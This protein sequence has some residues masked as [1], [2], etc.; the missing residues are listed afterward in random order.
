MLS[1]KPEDEEKLHPEAL[2]WFSL[3][4]KQIESEVPLEELSDD[5]LDM[6]LTDDEKRDFNSLMGKIGKELSICIDKDGAPPNTNIWDEIALN[7]N[8]LQAKVNLLLPMNTLKTLFKRV[9]E[10]KVAKVKEEQRELE[11]EQRRREEE[12]REKQKKREEEAEAKRREQEADER[13]RAAREAVNPPIDDAKMYLDKPGEYDKFVQAA[14]ET[15]E[16][17]QGRGEDYLD[18]SRTFDYRW[19]LRKIKH[20]KKEEQIRNDAQAQAQAFRARL[21]QGLKEIEKMEKIINQE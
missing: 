9:H 12:A 10:R 11:E 6:F 7:L 16:V 13:W 21:D 18:D 3:L 15:I 5:D 19:C 14:R 1:L 20:R 17:Y 2:K 4:R 8:A